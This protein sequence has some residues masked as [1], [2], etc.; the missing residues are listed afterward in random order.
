[1]KKLYKAIFYS[2]LFCTTAFSIQS[3]GDAF[4]YPE[5]QIIDEKQ[6]DNSSSGDV[7]LGDVS[8]EVLEGEMRTAMGLAIDF[9]THKY[10][11]QRSTNI[12]VFAGY[13]T[14]SKSKF[15]F[16]QPLCDTMVVQNRIYF[17]IP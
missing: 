9:A 11:Y 10:Q 14:V 16:G 6:S 4:D 15:D 13:F 3:C 5:W 2:G 8:V 12:D 1:M 17:W 7:E